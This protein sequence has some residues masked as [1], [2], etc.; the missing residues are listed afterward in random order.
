VTSGG[1]VEMTSLPA[2]LRPTRPLEAR[3]TPRGQLASTTLTAGPGNIPPPPTG[4]VPSGPA[5]VCTLPP[6]V[7]PGHEA[8][9]EL[10]ADLGDAAHVGRLGLTCQLPSGWTILKLDP[11][12]T[13]DD[14]QAD[15]AV[16]RN[17]HPAGTQTFR[18]HALAPLHGYGWQVF[19]VQWKLGS[20]PI[21]AGTGDQRLWLGENRPAYDP[22]PVTV[23]VPY[24]AYAYPYPYAYYPYPYGYWGPYVGVGVDLGFGWGGGWG[25]HG[26][27]N[28]WR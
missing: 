19:T 7:L 5:V 11:A 2:A 26:H 4:A 1:T 6:T 21:A 3:M 28:H 13:E 24:P 22:N 23:V 20:W 16:W 27:W 9:I 25:G 10:R 14:N 18:V 8:V 17:D 15:F 12:T